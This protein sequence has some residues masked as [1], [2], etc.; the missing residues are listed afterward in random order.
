VSQL[1]SVVPA[2]AATHFAFAV[3]RLKSKMDSGF[4]RNDA[5]QGFR[6]DP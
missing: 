2:K 5:M 6:A 4:R 3:L 1:H